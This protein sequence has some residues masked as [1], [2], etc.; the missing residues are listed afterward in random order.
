MVLPLDRAFAAKSLVDRVRVVD[1]PFVPE[2]ID[3]G[4]IVPHALLPM[5]I[6]ICENV[7]LIL[8]Y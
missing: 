6:S 2:E 7:I 8:G 5:T 4:G 1:Q 3:A